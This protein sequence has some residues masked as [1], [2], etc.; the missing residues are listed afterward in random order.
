[1]Q[2]SSLQLES[3]FLK[4]VNF[5]LNEDI[6]EK[7]TEIKKSDNLAIEVSVLVDCL[8]KEARRWRCELTLDL[9]PKDESD[10]AY[11]LHLVLVG[12]FAVSEKFPEEK[13]EMLAKST[14]PAI[15]YTTAREMVVTVVRRSPY[16][17]VLIPSVNFLEN[18]P[19]SAETEKPQPARKK[20]VRKKKLSE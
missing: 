11:N 10:S 19:K 7:P 3:Y 17:P 9:K 13:V 14:C 12:F 1:M 20:V 8:N 5:A 2:L 6:K 15:L 4:E 18:E 16:A